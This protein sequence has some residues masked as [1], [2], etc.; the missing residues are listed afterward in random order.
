M[1]G[2]R[3]TDTELE[4]ERERAWG[5]VRHEALASYFVKNA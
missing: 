5:V 4:G 1:L 3:Q 2:R